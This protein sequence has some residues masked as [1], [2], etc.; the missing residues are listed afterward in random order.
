[1]ATIITG[2]GSCLPGTIV[3]NQD[4][5]AWVDL[6]GFDEGRSGPYPQWVS[7]TMGF[8][9]RRWAG[10]DQATSDLA[11]EAAS[12]A[13]GEAGLTPRD[14]GLLIVST[15]TPDKKV[16]NT[17]SL[18]QGKLKAGNCSLAFDVGSA[19][20]GFVFALHVAEAMMNQHACYKHA[21]VV[22]AEKVTSIVNKED[23]ITCATF[24]DGAGAVVLSRS[25]AQ[26]CGILGS[27]ARSDGGLADLVE[28]PA[29]G[30]ALPI[31]RENVAE[32]YA[33]GWHGVKLEAQKLKGEAIARLVD[34]AQTVLRDRGLSP[35][36][37]NYWL[38]HQAGKIIVEGVAEA[39]GL[40][41]ETILTNYQR[42]GNTSQASIPMLLHENRRLFK[43]GD[44][45]MMLAMGGGLGW[46]SVL[47]QWPA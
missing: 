33:Q 17:A 13:L 18:V 46:G 42:Y 30:S 19:C 11:L 44:L 8:E 37:I 12:E 20:S 14:I 31:T 34:A 26:G 5:L 43:P 23:F 25:E 45:I 40:S 1:V 47:Y 2:T 36:D 27:Y 24:G 3:T 41:R 35:K 39:L 15:C 7:R 29:G 10:Q 32:V 4:L 6:S 16:P 21:L 38:P 9:E 28:V 22:A